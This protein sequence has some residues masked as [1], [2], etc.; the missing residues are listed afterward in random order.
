MSLNNSI[1]KKYILDYDLIKNIKF[2][3][4]KEDF[5]KIKPLN[6]TIYDILSM[7]YI[8]DY[9]HYFKNYQKWQLYNNIDTDIIDL[10]KNN[11]PDINIDYEQILKIIL[12]GKVQM[13]NIQ[14]IKYLVLDLIDKAYK[15]KHSIRDNCTINSIH[16]QMKYLA[17]KLNYNQ[18]ITKIFDKNIIELN[19]IDLKMYKFIEEIL[20][21]FKELDNNH[22]FIITKKI[23][24]N[25]EKDMNK[26]IMIIIEDYTK[27]YKIYCE[28]LNLKNISLLIS[29][30]EQIEKNFI[31]KIDYIYKSHVTKTFDHL[32]DIMIMNLLEFYTPSKNIH[33]LILNTKLN[34]DFINIK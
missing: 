23:L 8:G 9:I 21:N 29:L 30:K 31:E 25:L 34:Y 4:I 20:E 24:N 3:E 15:N 1:F 22:D 27:E 11:W 19:K 32:G 13:K 33:A 2:D 5:L 17:F 10:C 14:N 28:K 6:I 16:L 26:E 7:K 12:D 18:E